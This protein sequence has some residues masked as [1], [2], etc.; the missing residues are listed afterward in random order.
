M[1]GRWCAARRFMP[2]PFRGLLEQQAIIASRK[3]L[4]HTVCSGPGQPCSEIDMNYST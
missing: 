4:L 2:L 1:P 3:A